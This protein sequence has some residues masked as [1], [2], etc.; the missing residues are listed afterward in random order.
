MRRG[1]HSVSWV[2][3]AVG[4]NWLSAVP[5][6]QPPSGGSSALCKS[7]SVDDLNRW[8][9]PDRK[10]TNANDWSRVDGGFQGSG[11]GNDADETGQNEDG[12]C[13]RLRPC[14][15]TRNPSCIRVVI[16]DEVL[17]LGISEHSHRETASRINRSRVRT[18]P[19]H[20]VHPATLVGRDQLQDVDE[21][22]AQ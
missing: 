12:E 22:H 13:E 9:D 2:Y 1:W 3:W 11:V 19:H 21:R 15:Q 6:A 18:G 14:C 16:R 5:A 7:V 8:P 4:R 10:V 17:D 20:P